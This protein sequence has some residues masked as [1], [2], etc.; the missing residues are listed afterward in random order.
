SLSL[1]EYNSRLSSNTTTGLFNPEFVSGLSAG[2]SQHLLNG[3]GPRANSRF[4]RIA[5][6]NLNY[7]MSVFRQNVITTVAAVIS[8]YYDL[9]A[10]QESIRVAREG[11]QYAQKLLESNQAELKIGA[12][13]QYDVLRSQEEVDAR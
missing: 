8:T 11:L 13:A 7:S 6:N 2:I 10:D 4:I 3:F 5:R 1:S 9:L 12:V